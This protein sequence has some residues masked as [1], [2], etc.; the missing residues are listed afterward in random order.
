MAP[1]YF[2]PA[3]SIVVIRARKPSTTSICSAGGWRHSNSAPP[4]AIGRNHRAGDVAR[5]R[6]GEEN[7]K[8]RQILR[9]APIAHRNLFL[10]K[11]L[12]KIFRIVAAD[13][14]AH[15]PA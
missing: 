2:P 10:G 5:H 4:P 8:R 12:A 11:V 3:S 15:D 14:L 13:L 6:R 1:T 7:R 9:L